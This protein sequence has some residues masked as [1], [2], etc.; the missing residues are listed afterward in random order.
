MWRYADEELRSKL[1]ARGAVVIQGPKWCGK[2]TTA[3]QAAKSQVL[4]LSPE[5]IVRYRNIFETRPKALLNGDT[6]RLIDEW[7]LIPELWDAVRY[8]VDTRSEP[9]QFILTG[10]ATPVD[11]TKIHHSGAGRFSVLHMRTMSLFESQE[12]TGEVSLGGL[13]SAPEEI[14]GE[15]KLDLEALAYSLVRGGWPEA[16]QQTGDSAL[17]AA[18]DYI[19]IL[20]ESDLSGY[21]GVRR[22]AGKIKA[23]LRALARNISQQVPITTIRK[24]MSNNGEALSDDSVASY[25]NALKDMYVVED[26]PAWNPNLR[27]KAAIRTSDTRHFTD[28]SIAAAALRISPASLLEDLET[29][30]LFF[31][32]LVVRDLRI[33]ASHLS[34]T[35]YHYRDSNGKEA[36]AVLHLDNGKYALV[37]VKLRSPS[38]ILDAAGKLKA[39]EENLNTDAMGKPSFRMVVTAGDFAYRMKDG[40]YVVPLA[41]L[42]A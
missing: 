20:A 18:R 24:D 41:C 42:R 25:I 14:T 1:N 40:T 17:Q 29:Y 19:T 33:Y 2:S 32:S 39:I 16:V 15:S 8:E 37:E 35:V 31:E 34:G 11:T 22:N 36:D 10:S 21:T 9:G 38:A 7:Q 5:D 4:L 26:L 30:G 3:M 27:S 23:L 6:P 12:S 28:P 13:F